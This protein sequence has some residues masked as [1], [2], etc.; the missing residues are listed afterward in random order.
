LSDTLSIELNR[1]DA[2][3]WFDHRTNDKGTFGQLLRQHFAIAFHEA[4]QRICSAVGVG[5]P[6]VDEPVQTVTPAAKSTAQVAASIQ[7]GEEYLLERGIAS[8][9]VAAYG[10][11]IDGTIERSRVV[12]RLGMEISH[13]TQAIIWFPIR[14]AEGDNGSWIARPLPTIEGKAKFLCRKSDGAPLYI[15]PSVYAVRDKAEVPLIITEGSAKA[16]A[17]V[18]AGFH[19]IGVN[20]VWCA[21]ETDDE[22]KWHLR[23]E[24]REGFELRSRKVY[25]CFDADAATKPEVRHAQIRLFFLFHCA[26]A[27]VYQLTSWDICEGK[28]IDPSWRGKAWILSNRWPHKWRTRVES[29][30]TG[31]DGAPILFSHPEPV[32]FEIVVNGSP[33]RYPPMRDETNETDEREVIFRRDGANDSAPRGHLPTDLPPGY[34]HPPGAP[35]GLRPRLNP[36]RPRPGVT[37]PNPRRP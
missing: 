16:L 29:V 15:A 11:E 30:M 1:E 2:G 17:C 26:G 25:I 12:D 6:L 8:E 31:P 36:H 13:R 14:D 5:V 27:E 3:L 19:A 35:A 23:Q 10:I 4:A 28:G 18:Q 37:G 22:D 20:G 21:G 32:R 34:A 7:L 33:A 24:L 9:T